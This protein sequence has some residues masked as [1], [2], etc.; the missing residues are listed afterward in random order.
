M[1]HLT[2]KAVRGM[3]LIE[4]ILNI[5]PDGGTGSSEALILA[6]LVGAILLFVQKFDKA[7]SQK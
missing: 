6:A 3:N 5:S 4:R 2:T 1:S 7:H